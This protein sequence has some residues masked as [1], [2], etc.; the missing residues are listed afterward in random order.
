MTVPMPRGTPPEGVVFV[1]MGIKTSTGYQS[2]WDGSLA[3]DKALQIWMDLIRAPR[4]VAGA[5]EG[6]EQAFERNRP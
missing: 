1:R 5:D 6:I 2:D 3:H 4:V